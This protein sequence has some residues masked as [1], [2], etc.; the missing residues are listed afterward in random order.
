MR[1][2][3][4]GVDYEMAGKDLIDSVKLC[5]RNL[6]RARRHATGGYNYELFWTTNRPEKFRSQRATGSTNRRMAAVCQPR[7]PV[8]VHGIASRRRRSG[9]YFDVI[10]RHADEYLQFLDAYGRQGTKE[11]LG[12]PVWHIHN[13]APPMADNPVPF[14]HAAVA[15]HRV[16][17]RERGDLVGFIAPLSPWC[18]TADASHLAAMDR[19]R[20]SHYFRDFVLPAKKFREPGAV[21]RAALNRSARCAVATSTRRAGRKAIQ[22]VVYEVGRRE[23]FLDQ[24]KKGKDG[25]PGVSLDWFNMLYQVLLR[26]GERPALRLLRRRLRHQE[27][28]RHDRRRAGKVGV[29]LSFTLPAGEV[30]Q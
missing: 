6:P 7:K 28:R 19:I 14:S 11:Q 23:P 20:P 29:N 18:D 1:W 10:P 2:V 26:S 24:K 4:L 15:R 16:E 30:K 27:Y 17:C 25:K 12:N 3:A 9:L 22:D 5:R 21:G 13:G 8:A